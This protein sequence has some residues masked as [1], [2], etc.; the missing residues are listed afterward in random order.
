M[1]NLLIIAVLIFAGVAGYKI[2]ESMSHDAVMLIVGFLF[3]VLAGLPA[4]LV[5]VASQRRHQ[6]DPVAP[7]PHYASTPQQA[8]Q[9]PIIVLDGGQRRQD[10]TATGGNSYN[11]MTPRA[12][13]FGEYHE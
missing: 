1:K 8:Q 7:M 5:V 11:M 6:P 12:G 4:A 2:N 13:K 9:P 3:G 10:I